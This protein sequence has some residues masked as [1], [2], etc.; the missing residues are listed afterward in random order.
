MAI[1]FNEVGS[2]SGPGSSDVLSNPTSL[3]FGPDGR[4][5][6]SEQN[7]SINAFTVT[8]QDGQ[9]VATAHETLTLASGLEVVKSIQNHNDDG[10][11]S[12][13][14]NRQVTGVLVGGTAENPVLY[15]SSSDPRIAQNGEQNLDTNSGVITQVTWNGSDW[16][17][18]DIVRGLPRS[19]ENHSTNGMIFSPDGTKLLVAQGGNTN[20]GAPSGFFSYTGEYALSGAI[21]EIDL[22]AIN[23]LPV[24]T[25]PIGG[26][27]GTPRQYVYDLPT[28]DDV[29]V[30]NNGVREDANGLDTAGPWGGNDGFNMSILPADAPLRIYADGLRNPYDLAMTPSGQLYTVDNGSNGGLGGNPNTAGGE[31]INT[32]NNGGSG[33]PEP[34]FLIEDGGY[35]GHPNPARSNQNL[36]WTV[37][38]DSGN[39]DGSVSPN[40]VADLSAQVPTGINIQPG[41]LI[42]PSKFTGD[43]AR[44]LESGIRVEADSAESSALVTLGSSSNGLAVYS[45]GAFDGALDGALIVTQFNGNVTLLN[46]N[47]AGDDVVSLIGPGADGILGT[48]DDIVEDADGV[49]PISTGGSQPL[50]VTVGPD[51]T[52]WVAE[53]GGGIKVYAPSDLV[54]PDDPDFDNDGLL[55]TV[56]P[57]IRDATNGALVAV[58]PGQTLLWDFDPNQDGNRPG[59]NGYGGGLTGVMVNGTTD[60]E[61]FFQE[62]STLP[63]Q[64]INLDNVKFTTAAGGG[65]TVIESVSNGDPF[66]GGNSGEYLFHTGV[67]IPQNVET[68]NITWTVI[69]PGDTLSGNFQQIGGYIGTGDQS[70]YLKIVAIQH[71][72]GE[73]QVALE[74]GDAAPGSAQQFI[75]ADDIFN[76][77]DADGKKI[78]LSFEIDIAAETATPTV[79][80]ETATGS[81]TVS[82]T[83]LSIAN[84]AVL[85]AIKGDYTVN[86]QTTGLAVGLFSTNNGQ[87]PA[88]TFQAI[89]DGIEITATGDASPT[90]LY[91]VNAGGPEIVAI[92]GGPNWTADTGGS[93]S[94][95]LSDAGSGNVTGFAAV[96]PG[97]TVAVTTPGE[98]F[99][100]ERWDNSG[101]SEMQ[102]AFNVPTA[103]L[104]EVRLF[105]GNGFSGTGATGQRIFDVAI[106]GNVPANLND[107]DLSSQ[108]G[109]EVGA[110]ISNLV[111]VNDGV[112]NIEFQHGVENPL[113]N[114]IEIIQIGGG[115]PTLPSVSIVGGD[116]NVQEDAGQVQISLLTS[117]TVP[118]GESVT[119]SF[120]IVPGTAVADEDYTYTS[121]TSSFDA[122][123]G[124]YSDTVTIAGSSSDV[125]FLIDIINDT[126]PEGSEAFSVVLTGVSPNA[127]LG[128]SSANVT[129]AANDAVI[130][131]GDVVYRV[132]AG[133]AEVAANDGGPAWTADQSA[134]TANGSAQ[135]GTPSPFLVDRSVPGDDITYGDNTPSGPGTN[136]TGAPDELFVTERYSTLA[137]PN[138]IGYAFAVANGTY[139]VNLYFDELFHSSANS[140]VFDVSIEG[141]LVLNDFDT[142]ATYQNNTG[143]QSFIAQVND[144]EL[145]IEFGKEAIDNPHVAA[146]EIVAGGS[147]ALP[148]DSVNGVAAAGGDFSDDR[149]NPTVVTLA[150]GS[151]EI[152]STQEGDP[153]RDFDYLTF[154]VPVGSELSSVTLTGFDDYDP[155]EAN[156]AFLGLQ[157]GSTFTE[158][159]SSPNPANL[160][161]GAIFGEFDVGADLLSRLG[162]GSVENGV[163]TIGFP[164]PLQ[165]GTYT[166]WWSQNGGPTTSTLEFQVDAVAPTGT[167]VAAINAGGPAL[168]QD[169]IAFSADTH[170]DNGSTF[171]DGNAGNGQQPAFDGTVYETE[172]YGGASGSAALEYSIP[173]LSGDYAVELYF[174]EIFLPN[175][176]G[177]GIGGR[178]FDVFIEGQLVVDDLDILATT[179]GNINQPVIINVPGTFSPDDD[180]DTGTLDISFVGSSDNAKVSGIV[181]RDVTPPPGVIAI[182]NAA[183]IVESGD[184]GTTAVSFALTGPSDLNGPVDLAFSVGGVA[185]TA[186]V[187]FTN[188][189]GNLSVDVTND[190]LANGTETVSITDLAVTSPSGLVA[191]ST[192]NAANGTVTEDDFA[193]VAV[194][195]AVETG[196]DEALVFAASTL[197]ANDTDADNTVPTDL[198]VLSVAGGG[199]G[200]LTSQGGT[201]SLAVNGDITYTPAAGFSGADTFEYTVSDLGGNTSTGTVSV[202]VEAPPA[203]DGA[204]VLTITAGGSDVQDSNFGNNSFQISNTGNKT[205]AQ[206]DIDVTNALFPDSVFDPFGVAGDTV[207]KELT[208]NTNGGT[209]VNAPTAASYIGA[210]GIAGFEGLRLTFDENVNG[211]FENGETVGFSVDMDPNSIAGANKAILD[212]GSNPFWDI[213]G[214]SGAELIGSTFTVTFTDGT[215]ATG[216]LQGDNSQA[217]AQGIATQV[218]AA[219]P[220]S[221]ALSVNGLAAGGAG[222]Y[223]ATGPTV[224][225]DGTA[226]E[227][228]RVVLAKGFIQPTSNNFTGSYAAQLDAQLA[229]LAATSFPANNAAEFQT[230]DV[231]LTGG[232]Q[233][234]SSLFDFSGVPIYDFAGEDQLPLGFVASIIDPA[235]ND[236]PVGTV[237]SPIYLQYAEAPT[238]AI[239]DATGVENGDAGTTAVAF[240]LLGPPDLNGPVDLAFLQD[241]VATTAQVTFISGGATLTVDVAN[242]DLAN[243]PE[244]VSITDLTVTSPSGISADLA[245]NSATGTVSEDDFAPVAVGDTAETGLDQAVVITAAELLANDTDQDNLTAELAITGAGVDGANGV[246]AQGGTVRIGLGGDLTYT[247]AAGFTGQDSFSYTVSDPGGN[248]ATA[249]VS[250]GV[251][252]PPASDGSAVLTVTLGVNNV[253]GSNFGNSSFQITNTGNKTIAQVDI[254][255]TNA[256][257][258]DSVFD[259]FGIAGDTLGKPLTIN[260]NGGTGVNAPSAASYIGAGGTAGFEGLRLTFDQN[261]NGGFETGETLGFSVDMDPNSIA[262]AVKSILD[263]GASPAW[264][265]GGI[266]GA[267][268]IGSSFT[269][270]FTDGT[271]ATGQLQG[272]DTQAGAQGLATQVPAA[273]PATVALTV[274][275]LAAGGVGTYNQSGP[276]IIIDGTAGETARVV[277]AKG[278][279]QPEDNNFTGSYAAQ[280]DAQLAALAASDFPA[281]N[282]VEFQT[283][284]VVLTGGPQDISS[285]FDFSGVPIY[286]FDGEDELPLG[287]VASIIDPANNDLPVG[288]VSSPIYLQFEA[289]PPGQIIVGLNE[290]E[291]LVLSGGYEV[292]AYAPAS[293]GEIIRGTNFS[294]PGAATGTFTGAQGVYDLDVSYFNEPDGVSQ[295]QLLV[296]GLVVDSWS[297]TGGNNAFVSRVATASLE[298]GDTIQITGLIN[299]GE[300]ARVDSLTIT[301][302][303]GPPPPTGPIIAVGVTEAESLSLAGGYQVN[304]YAPASG[305]EIIR[306]TN[307]NAP[308]TATGTFDGVDG[309]YTLTVRYFNEPDGVSQYALLVNGAVVD[310]WNG[311]G[312]SDAFVNRDISLS[313]EDGDVIQVRGQINAG[314]FARIDTLT[315]TSDGPPPPN[316]PPVADDDTAVTTEDLAVS[317]NVLNG[318][319]DTDGTITGI[320]QI[321][322]QAAA[323]G[324]AVTLASGAT[325]TLLANGQISYDPNGQFEAL[326]TGQS[327]T[328]GFSYTIVDDDRAT[329]VGDVTVTIN[330]VTDVPGNQDPVVSGPVIAA[331]SEDD[332]AATVNLLAGASDPDVGDT[333][334][335]SNLTLVSGN[336]AGISASGNV[337]NVNPNAYDALNTGQ[338]AV[339][340]YSYNVIDGNGGTVSQTSTVTINGVTDGP[341]PA[342]SIVVGLNE[343]EDLNLSGGYEVNSYGPS[344]GGELIRGTNFSGPG[345]ATGTFAGA[346]GVYDLDVRYFNEDDGVA[347]WQLLVDGIVV[348]SWSGTGGNNSFVNRVATVSLDDGD[349]IQ[350][351]GRINGGEFARVDSLTVTA[352]DGPPPPS[353][354]IIGVGVTEAETLSLAGGYQVNQ[355]APASGGEIIRGTNY[356]GP[357]TAT[358]TFDG[359]SGDYNLAVKYFNEPDGVSQ[360]ALLVNGAVV[361]SWSGTGGNDSF[362]TRD[363][364]LSL[365]D[366]DTIQVRGQINA[367]EFARIDTLELT[368]ETP[369]ASG[370]DASEF[371]LFAMAGQSNGERFFFRETGDNSPG[372]LAEVVFEDAVSAALDGPVDLIDA[373]TGGSASNEGLA[374]FKFWWNLTTDEPGP[375]LIDSVAAIDAAISGGK[376]LD[377][378]IWAHGEADAAAIAD[379]FSNLSEIVDNYT[380]A[381]TAVFEYF[382]SE[383]GSDVSIF[384]Q[385][386]GEFPE[387]PGTSLGGPAGALD[388]IRDAQA[389]LVA[390][391]PNVYFGASTQGVAQFDDLHFTNEGYG[392]I[393][394][395]LAGSVVNLLVNGD[396]II[397]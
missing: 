40:T 143:V 180:A 283:V 328:D 11:L 251:D 385:E 397:A 87:S 61:V 322:G 183:P 74:N 115:G 1:N 48:G 233:D 229:A 395:D 215:T 71:P 164:T 316:V 285:L 312:G 12:G 291:D 383:Y 225:I 41:F 174:A 161:G 44:L 176:G 323:V 256:L 9:Y 317:I 175:G 26:Q 149:L 50:D 232:L 132:N 358:G 290:A 214:I 22:T 56:D 370:L 8:I 86:G 295:W 112:L 124:I 152:V 75:Q 390:D 147:V 65:T 202:A 236:L 241:G 219:S 31:A 379:D 347:Q 249:T 189:A 304:Q 270:T 104:Y 284:D 329:D 396:Q 25:D 119:V 181:V 77:D 52:V 378:I 327:A 15:I 165:A 244:T 272:D 62:P 28:L 163:S 30:A 216:Q 387:G 17:A 292:N 98:I 386:L 172:R 89:F 199:V 217:G 118:A 333:V 277:L 368:A 245:A 213:G 298:T 366:G 336:A 138:N 97:P 319:I 162:D 78:L 269:V 68:F 267:E 29:S 201:V 345:T 227:T 173:V 278:F 193:P 178:V 205:I 252:A 47:A 13:Q 314:E 137:N 374:N 335:V 260:T 261:T 129:I 145:N 340:T 122:Q 276:S 191:S 332:A 169:G 349:T 299:N 376:D 356:V 187:T 82:G 218:P 334:S 111:T 351:T 371:D 220:T 331:F 3:Q 96:D 313:L 259:P 250:V 308:G 364:A 37:Y 393:A 389:A 268:L 226:G 99:D 4:L 154:E 80:Y 39:P 206:V 85:D 126:L 354:P 159:P 367:G 246:T 237:S 243:G 253:Q 51:G 108:F 127:Q 133:G 151:T 148:D 339:V 375:T 179:G 265:I 293:G 381:T 254:D 5:Y 105:M 234:I 330:G 196:Q 255:V 257:F 194:S 103:G 288:A 190:D 114:G 195:D 281:N 14:G 357:G 321:N 247:P 306:G 286:N 16:E 168:T 348:D 392:E 372:D 49:F 144:G 166:L 198:S 72:N 240:A 320:T 324:V 123:S 353:G 238:V 208:I 223:D 116:Q 140:R 113:V 157:A 273:S 311:A 380:A 369:P 91:R 326:N 94:P 34:L 177:T 59:P 373:A 35:Y 95:F 305:G 391:L 294:S 203:Q 32:P 69:N 92:D 279:I 20:N 53:I 230:V 355:Y 384:M 325:A 197:L 158:D 239:S 346:S 275:G 192:A 343:A 18:I 280:L 117:A 221:V 155:G 66:T 153:N 121:G 224:I 63:G 125:T 46:L 289:I 136:A 300:F 360:Y 146:I 337:L 363:I 264:D 341:P 350:I 365:T 134:V 170:F 10:S 235:N 33:D 76:V 83:A 70:N 258:P 109:N 160:L 301:A 204:A 130:N 212:S 101:G 141:G 303:D 361:D 188:G 184:L 38:N 27:G 139:T 228:A 19:E 120:D 7:G 209:G 382:W 23:A 106:E 186:Q 171:T 388:A 55:N 307:Y 248:T 54:L 57:F 210:G 182:A 297:G 60:F 81:T 344:S 338:S 2:F 84:S 24:L 107:V 128:T 42:D 211:G 394:E 100:T 93:P 318:D 45:G 342:G 352:S 262:G 131:P 309:D 36:P 266:S 156:A 302:S 73:I 207:G 282:A 359:T 150:N 79:I 310:T 287:F 200:G 90:V 43:P 88:N 231:V 315:L 64:I 167:I 263:S 362:V 296:N 110:M 21:L 185:S 242:D 142:Y 274:N 377:G 271:T 58:Q 67:T 6:V 102:W 222:T 135:I